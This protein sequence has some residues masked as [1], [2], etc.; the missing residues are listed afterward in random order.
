MFSEVYYPNGWHATV[1]GQP[2]ELIRADWTLRAALLPAGEHEVVMTFLPDS[3]RT[4]AT[5]SRIA[6]IGLLALLLLALAL[7]FIRSTPGAS[8]EGAG[9]R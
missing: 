7:A 6:S 5:V 1:D 3:Y 8:D 2:L 9:G 4:G